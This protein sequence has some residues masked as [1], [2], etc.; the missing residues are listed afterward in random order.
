MPGRAGACWPV[1]AGRSAMRVCGCGPSPGCDGAGTLGQGR[2]LPAAGHPFAQLWWAWSGAVAT[3]G[4]NQ[5]WRPRRWGSDMRAT[6]R[7]LRPERSRRPVSVQR[8][9]VSVA[10]PV[11]DQREQFACRGNLGDVFAAASF[12]S[13]FVGCDLGRRRVTLHRL[14]GR[15]TNQ[16]GALFGDMPAVYDAIGLAVARGQPGPRAQ[17]GGVG[18]NGARHRSRRRTPPLAWVRCRARAGSLDSRGRC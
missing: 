3:R 5:E 15:P 10:Q 14:D 9:D 1:D 4:V 16:F 17:V 6:A 18:E 2:T 12:D 7:G 8:A 13:V 11:V